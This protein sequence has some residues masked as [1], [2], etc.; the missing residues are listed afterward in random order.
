MTSEQNINC[1]VVLIPF[2]KVKKEI[3]N[4]MVIITGASRL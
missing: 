3:I 2:Q 1:H 4:G